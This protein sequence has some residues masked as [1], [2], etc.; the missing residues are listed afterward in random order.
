L[1]LFF[2]GHSRG[3]DAARQQAWAGYLFIAPAMVIFFV[4]TL[5]PVAIALYL[6]FTNYDV[7]T[8]MDW[9]G[10]ANYQDVFDD[11]FFWRAL[12]N[13]TTYTAWTIP[14]SM[15]I[16][17]GLA[18][19]LNQKLRGLGAYRTIY[20]IPVVTSMVAVAMIWIQLFDPLYGVLSN[21]LEA[22]GIK[23]IDWLGDPNL[24]M[25]S[26]IAVSVWKVIGWNM[27]IYLAGLQG[28]PAYLK[29][30]AAIDG[31]NRW[32]T[33]WNIVL[34]LLQPT[35]FFI[36]VTSLIGAFQVFDQVYVMTGGGPANATT[37]LVH[38][39]YNA[40]FKALDM[41]YAAAMSFVLFGI[42]L[43][44]SLFSMRAIRSEVAYQ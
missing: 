38:Q 24:A 1:F 28:I 30:A 9:I 7:F 41:G 3:Y 22:V 44:V 23:G 36:F 18:L 21:G 43:V 20:Y 6:S 16:G 35:T 27:L 5:L 10:T 40:A 42:I 26:I 32:Q 19:L 8:K 37:T 31:A 13:T 34:P 29:E 11:E 12:W 4:F 15:A 39:I 25:P 14:L 17:L 33:F 2:A